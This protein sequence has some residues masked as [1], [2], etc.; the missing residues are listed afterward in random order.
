M[1]FKCK[2]VYQFQSIE[3]DFE[4]KSSED[5]TAMFDVY[6]NVLKGLMEFAPDQQKATV[7]RE[8]PATD[9]QREIMR[10]NGIPFTALT[11][12]SEAQRLIEKSLADANR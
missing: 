5:L 9:K 4:V 8:P 1:T 7:N 12:K 3:F 10:I 6:K 11:T 2:P